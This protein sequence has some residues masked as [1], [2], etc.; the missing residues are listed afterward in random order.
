M[1]NKKIIVLML[2]LIMVVGTALPSMA[3]MST[4]EKSKWLIDKGYVKGR[5]DNGK[6]D[7]AF[8]ENIERD[9]IT[10]MV[11]VA[12]GQEK[13]V[14]SYKSK[15]TI[16]KDVAQTHWGIGEINLATSLGMVVGYPD[17]TFKPDN[18]ITFAELSAMLVRLDSRWKNVNASNISWPQGYINLAQQY[19][20]LADIKAPAANTYATRGLA[21]EM[22]YNYINK[23][24]NSDIYTVTFDYNVKNIPGYSDRNNNYERDYSLR[25]YDVKIKKDEVLGRNNMPANKTVRD[26]SY[27]N[28]IRDYSIKEWNTSADGRG[29][30]LYDNTKIS[31]NQKYYAIWS[32]DSSNNNNNARVDTIRISR[33]VGTSFYDLNLP[34]SVRVTYYD[35]DSRRDRTG[36]YNVEWYS[37]DY[38]ANSDREQTIRGD[39]K[40]LPSNLRYTNPLAKAIVSRNGSVARDIT[41]QFSDRGSTSGQAPRRIVAKS[42][43]SVSLPGQGSLAKDGYTFKGWSESYNGTN[44]VSS[45]Y[46]VPSSDITLYPIWQK[47]AVSQRVTITFNANGGSPEPEDQVLIKGERAS[48]P[49][50]I[51]REGYEFLGWYNG[52]RVWDFNNTVNSNMVLTAKW[53]KDEV[54]ENVVVSFNPAGGTPVASQTI[55]VGELATEPSAP[56]REGFTFSHWESNGAEWNFSTPVEGNMTLTAI[57]VLDEVE[58]PEVPEDSRIV[59]P[60]KPVKPVEDK[61]VTPEQPVVEPEATV[62]PEA[63]TTTEE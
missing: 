21:F 7:Y 14:A 45:F 40:G 23:G 30:R 52:S 1:K 25:S 10:K 5:L 18:S 43:S 56:T 48:D 58:D 54:P 33:P 15:T 50:E 24:N 4:T 44:P 37:N 35:S 63:T 29:S 62:T 26:K 9:E 38:S 28:N 20:I 49:G 57:W 61:P 27:N 13:N 12:A 16:F 31:G 51:T 42:G 32:A 36:D 8:N 47:D 53:E 11:V 55:A 34:R 3:A 41:I 6:I 59:K 19:G 17:G 60:V 39:V 2:A 46:R 22:I